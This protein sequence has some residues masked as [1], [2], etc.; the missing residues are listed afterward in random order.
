ML[1]LRLNPEFD[2]ER[3]AREYAERKCV[4]IP[5]FLEEASAARLEAVIPTLPWLILQDDSKQNLYLTREE[6][7][8]RSRLRSRTGLWR[9]CSG[10]LPRARCA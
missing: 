8:W 6:F 7:F 5:D 9:A 1:Q 10:A 2:T 3:L 4:Q